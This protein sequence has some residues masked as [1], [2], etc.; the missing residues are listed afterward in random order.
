LE[1]NHTLNELRHILQ[2]TAR[3]LARVKETEM[4]LQCHIARG[5]TREIQELE[6]QRDRLQRE[7]SDLEAKRTLL[8][9]SGSGVRTYI[10]EHATPREREEF[11]SLLEEIGGLI[12]QVQN[13]QEVNRSLLEERIR[14]TREMQEL[15]LPTAKTYDPSGQVNYRDGARNS[16]IDRSC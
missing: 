3:L 15:L 7:V 11:L 8:I 2:E 10:K 1:A 13:H 12:Y 14:F 16:Q 5:Q 6:Q 4:K 9:P